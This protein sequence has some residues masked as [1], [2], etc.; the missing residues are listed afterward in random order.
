[1]AVILNGCQFTQGY[2]GLSPQ[3]PFYIN[4]LHEAEQ[5]SELNIFADDGALYKEIK[6]SADCDLLQEDLNNVYFWSTHW[7]LRLS[8]SKCEALCVTN[9]HSPITATYNVNSVPL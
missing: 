6:S 4:D 1:M 2:P 5:Y 3:A 9:K 8:P 7:Q